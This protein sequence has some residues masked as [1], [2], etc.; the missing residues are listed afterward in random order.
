MLD[1]SVYL[2]SDDLDDLRGLLDFV[3]NSKTLIVI[4]SAGVFAQPRCL[5]EV[6]VGGGVLHLRSPPRC[7]LRLASCVLR[8]SPQGS[9]RLTSF[10]RVSPQ[11]HAAIEASIPVV[12]VAVTG[13]GFDF[14]SA[15][16]LVLHLETALD[17]A[18]PGACGMI[19]AAGVDPLDVAY[20]LS[21][22]LP[23][24]VSVPLDSSTSSSMATSL[25]AIVDA[26]SGAI[27]LALSNTPD[28][29]LKTRAGLRL[30]VGQHVQNNEARVVIQTAEVLERPWC[31]LEVGTMY[32]LLPSV[33]AEAN[34]LHAACAFPFSADA[35]LRL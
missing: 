20:K 1:S 26:V 17:C 19:K 7:C 8:R 24:I 9:V 29:W 3:R 6:G 13:K 14:A 30:A 23:S 32:S 34:P 18:N 33:S 12:A 21:S 5:L 2:D 16:A 22:A 25:R 35:V 27:P 11:I 31:L 28:Q 10:L 15:S 4:Q